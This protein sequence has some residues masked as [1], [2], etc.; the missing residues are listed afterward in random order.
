VFYLNSGFSK[1]VTSSP[2]NLNWAIQITVGLGLAHNNCHHT[3]TQIE[4]NASSPLDPTELENNSPHD[5]FSTD[6]SHPSDLNKSCIFT[7]ME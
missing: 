2:L 5:E 1:F 4:A 3:K 7:V 6:Y